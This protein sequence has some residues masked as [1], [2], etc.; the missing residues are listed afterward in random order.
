MTKARK[1][2]KTKTLPKIEQEVY[3]DYTLGKRIGEKNYIVRKQHFFLFA[4]K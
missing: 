4:S 3:I 2:R 1:R